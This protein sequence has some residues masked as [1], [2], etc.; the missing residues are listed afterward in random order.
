MPTEKLKNDSRST[1]SSS[2]TN[3]ATSISV[4][5][6]SQFPSSGRFRIRIDDELLVVTARSGNTLTVERG[7][8]GTTAASHSSGADVVHVLTYG[9][10]QR[11]LRDSFYFA[12]TGRPPYGRMLSTSNAILTKNDF[13]AVNQGT[14]SYD[15]QLGGLIITLTTQ[16]AS[17]NYFL[18]T[19]SAPSTPYS[20]TAAGRVSSINTASS[21]ATGWGIG[22]RESS[23][24]KF[25]HFNLLH[26]PTD[27]GFKLRVQNMDS[28]TTTNS[29]PFTSSLVPATDISWLRIRDDGTNLTFH[30]SS[31]GINFIQAHSLGRT[32]FLASG[33]NQV[34][35]SSQNF[36]SSAEAYINILNWIE[37][38]G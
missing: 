36:N 12:D 32:T 35:I 2:I 18:L 27:T 29:G 22:F 16:G 1:L 3:S 19:R 28:P 11:Y 15:D 17:N 6:G 30:Y 7:A 37:T 14:R 5:D 10:L 21:A 25:H 24:G 4:A 8:E 31:D 13:T 34:I 33:P 38:S 20:V 9:G 23:T 26:V